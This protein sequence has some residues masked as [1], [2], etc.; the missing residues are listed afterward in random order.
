MADE[1]PAPVS[2]GNAELRQQRRARLL[3]AAFLVLVAVI[4]FPMVL[5]GPTDP[6][7]AEAPAPERPQAASGTIDEVIIRR[8]PPPGLDRSTRILVSPPAGEAVSEPSAPAVAP[9]TRPAPEPQP[10]VPAPLV[11]TV[12]APVQTPPEPPQAPE[13]LRPAEPPAPPPVVEQ[14]AAQPSGESAV[15][16]P[17]PQPAPTP[18]TSL[19]PVLLQAGAFGER[20][21]AERLQAELEAMNLPVLTDVIRS[22]QGQ[23]LYR[24]RVGPIAGADAAARVQS[25]LERS[26]GLRVFVVTDRD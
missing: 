4:V 16:T 18:R 14:R 26:L 12:P 15:A 17:A 23:V 13:P 6:A 19:E 5:R 24:L 7:P 20:V 8:T 3:G 9:E 10:S 1:Q 25:R 21:N 11:R 22:P 2:G